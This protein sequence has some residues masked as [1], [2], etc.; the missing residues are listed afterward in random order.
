MTNRARLTEG[1]GLAG[2][3]GVGCERV[4]SAEA[5]LDANGG[6]KSER[7][8]SAMA[9]TYSAIST[10]AIGTCRTEDIQ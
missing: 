1:V 6:S 7:I 9:T 3:E 2:R 4:A 5:E 8:S 10:E